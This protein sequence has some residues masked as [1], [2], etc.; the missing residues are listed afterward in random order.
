[1]RGSDSDV[2]LNWWRQRRQDGEVATRTWW[3]GD[4]DEGETVT[5]IAREGDEEVVVANLTMALRSR[6]MMIQ[7][8]SGGCD[9]IDRGRRVR[10]I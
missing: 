4:D 3:R 9:V 8:K 7:S 1:M 2:V 5:A 10:Q 6:V